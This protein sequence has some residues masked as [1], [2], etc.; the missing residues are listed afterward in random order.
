MDIFTDLTS[1]N[2][3]FPNP[4]TAVCIGNFDGM[5][6]GHQQVVRA[7]VD[8]AKKLGLTAV[9][10]TFQSN[11]RRWKDTVCLLSSFDEKV[12]AVRSLG[13]DAL[14]TLPFPGYIAAQT[15]QTFV[16]EILLRRLGM[17]TCHVGQNFRFGKDRKGSVD[18]LIHY[19]NKS[20]F[21]LSVSE[22]LLEEGEDISSTRIRKWV[23]L[24]KIM[25]VTSML[26]RP[27]E[28]E[29]LVVKGEGRGKKLGYPTANILPLDS[30]KCIPA[31][32]IYLTSAIWEKKGYFSLTHIGPQPTFKGMRPSIEVHIPDFDQIL[33]QRNLKVLFLSRLR[34][35][36]AFKSVDE[37]KKQ[38]IADIEQARAWV[39]KDPFIAS[40][41]HR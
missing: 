25:E 24:G 30:L 7:M 38:I 17:K 14:I 22:M 11:T 27:F 18:F 10:L 4:S 13:A 15:P 35:V 36:V 39:R 3:A 37:L 33:Y 12:A 34:D 26:G 16:K 28:L 6:R 5:H 20:G 2:L 41:L 29:G 19:A 9:A 21:K 31:D 1:F 32:G 8:E 40:F 23:H